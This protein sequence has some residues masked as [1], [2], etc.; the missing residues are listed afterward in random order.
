MT[1]ERI[2]QLEYLALMKMR[3]AMAQNEAVRSAE[4]VEEENRNRERMAVIREFMESKARR[5]A[6]ADRN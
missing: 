3:K 5:P 1:R 2:R 4:E 6:K